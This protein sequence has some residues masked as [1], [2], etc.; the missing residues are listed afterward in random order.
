MSRTLAQ[1]GT[2][3]TKPSQRTSHSGNTASTGQQWFRFVGTLHCTSF[4]RWVGWVSWLGWVCCWC[5]RNHLANRSVWSAPFEPATAVVVVVYRLLL[6]AYYLLAN[7]YL[8]HTARQHD[9]NYY[10]HYL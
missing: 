10:Y 2:H 6:P 9:I 1:E 4:R 7:L 5:T 3:H 8:P